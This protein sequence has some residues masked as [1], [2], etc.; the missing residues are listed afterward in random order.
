MYECVLCSPQNVL[1]NISIH[2]NVDALEGGMD[3]VVQI[4]SCGEVY[5]HMY[6]DACNLLMW[7]AY[8]VYCSAYWH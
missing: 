4:L 5:T 8:N 7:A 1:R 6:M 2:L 3:G